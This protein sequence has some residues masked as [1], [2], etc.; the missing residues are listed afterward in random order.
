MSPCPLPCHLFVPL[1]LLLFPYLEN[2]TSDPYCNRYERLA[3]R[4]SRYILNERV[5]QLVYAEAQ[6]HVPAGISSK[7]ISI[8]AQAYSSLET[9]AA[10]EGYFDKEQNC[11][12]V[13]RLLEEM[14]TNMNGF[15][16]KSALGKTVSISSIS[17]EKC[18]KLTVEIESLKRKVKK[19]S[20]QI[21]QFKDEISRNKAMTAL[22]H[23]LS[24]DGAKE[25]AARVRFEDT[26][27]TKEQLNAWIEEIKP[28]FDGFVT[29]ARGILNIQDISSEEYKDELLFSALAHL[30]YARPKNLPRLFNFHSFCKGFFGGEELQ[31]KWKAAVGSNKQIRTILGKVMKDVDKEDSCAVLS[32]TGPCKRR[33]LENRASNCAKDT[34][35]DESPPAN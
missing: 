30:S 24:R 35:T 33:R 25:N 27:R 2:F 6:K 31:A 10:F 20:E 19:Q 11:P 17:V 9:M 32:T 26:P 8:S 5:G 13:N 28:H 3:K 16:H 15:W 4:G 34:K 23:R 1:P 22:Q 12:D 18:D 29:I 21:K 7:K 14:G